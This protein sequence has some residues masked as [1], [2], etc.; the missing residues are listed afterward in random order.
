MYFK[1]EIYKKDNRVM[2]EPYFEE[3]LMDDNYDRIFFL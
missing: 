2:V 3:I 1:N